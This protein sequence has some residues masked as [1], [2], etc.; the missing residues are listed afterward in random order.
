[1]TVPL[2]ATKG[3][4]VELAASYFFDVPDTTTLEPI[5]GRV[6]LG[7]NLNSILGLS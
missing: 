1:M 2:V 3:I 4:S 7:G 5:A 6:I